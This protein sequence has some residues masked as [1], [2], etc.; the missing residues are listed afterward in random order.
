MKSNWEKFDTIGGG[1]FASMRNNCILRWRGIDDVH[2]Q[3][4]VEIE[5]I[6]GL[7]YFM[8]ALFFLS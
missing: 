5:T 2:L 3:N 1:D 8:E 7:G 4:Q 6:L